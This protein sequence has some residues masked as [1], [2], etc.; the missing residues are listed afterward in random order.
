MRAAVSVVYLAVG[1]RVLA[2]L[3]KTSQSAAFLFK[4]KLVRA[5]SVGSLS[6]SR[7]RVC[8]RAV[9]LRASA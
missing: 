2:V 4:I 8:G 6:V 3:S 7:M 9:C 5:P 1:R